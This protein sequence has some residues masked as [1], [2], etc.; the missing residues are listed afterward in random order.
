MSTLRAV[1]LE[2]A[3]ELYR[4]F[5]GE[6]PDRVMRITL[7]P[8]TVGLVIGECDGILYTTVRDGEEERYIH[9][10]KARSKPLLCA[11]HDGSQLVIIGGRYRFTERG[12]VDE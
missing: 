10:F 5:T 8:V 9:E 1:N 4:R 2:R 7:E 11:S 6:R 3:A 12:I